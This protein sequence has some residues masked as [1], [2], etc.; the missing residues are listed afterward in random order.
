MRVRPLPVLALVACLG[1]AA[2]QNPDGSTD[3]GGTLAL[4]AGA[5]LAAALVAG[6]A[7]DDGPRH[8][9]RGGYG[10]GG[11]ERGG[12]GQGYGRSYAGARGGRGYE[13]SAYNVNSGGGYG[14]RW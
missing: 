1:T 5:G 7:S 12:Y 10:R 9:D 3:W 8:R 13:K 6:A 4:G 14:R 11:Y 2:C